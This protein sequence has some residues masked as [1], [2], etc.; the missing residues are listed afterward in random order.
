MRFDTRKQMD[1]SYAN[2]LHERY[3]KQR[4]RLLDA[5]LETAGRYDRTLLTVGTGS[6]ALSVT[7]L[8]KIAPAPVQWTIAVIVV[9]W[10]LLL[11]S[12]ICQLIALDRS[13]N[14]TREQ[15]S[16]LDKEFAFYFAGHDPAESVREG[17]SRPENRFVS[18][19]K[20]YNTIAR[21]CLFS[22]IVLI[23]AFS[24]LN[25]WMKE[26]SMTEDQEEQSTTENTGAE[27][28][29]GSYT[30]EKGEIPPPPPPKENSDEGTEED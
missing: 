20:L 1:K 17:F 7:F 26:D 3:V 13:E 5:S 27:H 4:E 30:P 6:L 11:A 24:A 18:Q 2:K 23:F 14:A 29:R 12:V 21:R 8:H 10:L 15:V 22:G 16:I 9:A 25:L 28:T 19:V